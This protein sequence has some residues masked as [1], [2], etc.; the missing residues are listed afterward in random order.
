MTVVEAE[1]GDAVEV[2]ISDD[3]EG[4]PDA[5]RHEIFRPF[6]T[7]KPQATGLGLTVSQSIV[8]RHGGVIEIDSEPGIGATV[9]VRLPTRP[10]EA[11]A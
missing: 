3:G 11:R 2:V 9:R 10:P 6:F 4:V 7:T 5:V 8:E 1:A